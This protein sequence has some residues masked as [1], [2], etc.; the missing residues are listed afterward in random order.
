[1]LQGRWTRWPASTLQ[2]ASPSTR[3]LSA[4]CG[5]KSLNPVLDTAGLYQACGNVLR[6]QGYSFTSGAY[7]SLQ[8]LVLWH[9]CCCG[10]N[11]LHTLCSSA[12]V[13]RRRN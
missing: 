3:A 13:L 12:N 9:H 2:S 7:H 5:L 4:A 6:I 11:S 1:M 10:L 8:A